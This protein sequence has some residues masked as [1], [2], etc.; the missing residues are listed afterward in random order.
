MNYEKDLNLFEKN[1]KIF[2]NKLGNIINFI[3]F[4]SV[5]VY[6]MFSLC[7]LSIY[8]QNKFLD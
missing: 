5:T 6:F 1:K 4:I 2:N 7:N 3:L 8:I